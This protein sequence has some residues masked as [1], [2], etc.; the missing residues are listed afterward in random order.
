MHEHEYSVPYPTYFHPRSDAEVR[1]WQDSVRGL[2]RRWLMAFVGAPRPDSPKHIRQWIIAQC[3]EAPS[4]CGQ[5]GCAFG[6]SQCHSPNEIMRLF[7]T[8]T[9]CLQPPG[10][11]YTRRS[12]FDSMVA[13]CIPVFFDRMTAYVQYKWH[14]PDDH[15]KYSVFIPHDD[16]RTGNV[17]I[18]AVLRAIQPE[19]VE[20]MREEVIGMIPRLL[21][22][23]PRSKLETVRDAF[24]VAV[25]GI[26]G[27][28]APPCRRGV[29]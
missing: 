23:D 10:D 29:V 6:S 11:S 1:R 5:L 7:Q 9:F 3:A 17:S 19:T 28:I 2:E 18:E 12:V 20:R 24:D 13:G 4:T 22:A 8:A 14:L 15:A 25:E 27:K 16:V 21:Y 26:V